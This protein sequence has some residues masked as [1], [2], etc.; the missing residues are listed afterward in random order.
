[1]ADL[2]YVRATGRFGLVIGDGAADPDVEPD[3]V[4]CDSGTIRITP[5]NTVTKVAGGDPSPWSAG[6]SVIDASV[7][8]NG[9]LTWREN[10]FVW[11]AD[12]GSAKV[13]PFI[14]PGKATHTIDFIDV[15]AG[16]SRVTFPSYNVR[17]SAD[18]VDPETGS[19]DLT[20][21]SPVAVSGGT[22]IIIGPPGPEG[23]QGPI[24]PTGGSP[25]VFQTTA[26]QSGTLAIPA[27]AVMMTVKGAG[28]GGGG[29]SGRVGA[30][31]TVR[32]GGGGGSG[33]GSF[34]YL[35]PL[36]GIASPLYFA[37]GAGGIGG[38][39]VATDDTNGNNGTAGTTTYVAAGP[40]LTVAN[41]V[42]YGAGG[43]AGGGGTNAAGT[44]GPSVGGKFL[45]LAGGAASVTGGA[46]GVG[47]TGYPGA[48]GGG[49]GGGIPTGNTASGGGQGGNSGGGITQSPAGGIAPG[50]AGAVGTPRLTL[51]VGPGGGGGASSVTGAAGAGGTGVRGGG[52][53]GGGAGLNGNPS[54]AGG[55]GANG[56]LEVT[57][58]F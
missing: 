29:G 13:N 19:C 47:Q 16:G 51:E 24:G 53:G 40:G 42:A 44:S 23:P 38:A 50:G 45:G 52:G 36:A 28:G 31:G 4:W 7:D 5:L 46:G 55:N 1:M 58:Y 17:I 6:H 30:A 25:Q 26:P 18:T 9:Y 34:D 48:T 14:G 15:M 20:L 12:L 11:L 41:T 57:F 37:V 33:G 21:L 32:C 27:G 49:A 43:N 10:P 8:A 22:P 56:F 3:T 2:D 39:A 35:V 54:G